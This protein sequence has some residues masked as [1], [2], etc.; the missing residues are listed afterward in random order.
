MIA[1]ADEVRDPAGNVREAL[2]ERELG[3]G[4]HAVARHRDQAAALPGGD[5]DRGASVEL[6][7]DRSRPVRGL[8]DQERSGT[9]TTRELDRRILW[10]VAGQEDAVREADDRGAS[11]DRRGCDGQR[12]ERSGFGRLARGLGKSIERVRRGIAQPLRKL[13]TLVRRDKRRDVGDEVARDRL[14]LRALRDVRWKDDRDVARLARRQALDE[15]LFALERLLERL[16]VG[17]HPDVDRAQGQD[18]RAERLKERRAAPRLRERAER[19][20]VAA[21]PL[22]IRGRAD[23]AVHELGADEPDRDERLHDPQRRGRGLADPRD[24]GDV[25][26]EDRRGGRGEHAQRAAPQRGVRDAKP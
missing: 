25:V 9:A 2:H 5:D 1:L 13:G 18:L 4:E 12:C 16:L 8:A 23:R 19:V 21:H 15:A 17:A 24:E 10:Q 11:R 26:R 6:R 22:A 20:P 14:E 3:L 7:E